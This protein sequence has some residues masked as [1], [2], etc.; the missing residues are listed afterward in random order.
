[1]KYKEKKKKDLKDERPRYNAEVL[2]GYIQRHHS[3]THS[4]DLKTKASPIGTQTLTLIALILRS[5][6]F[7]LVSYPNPNRYFLHFLL[8]VSRENQENG[9]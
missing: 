7:P 5:W 8:S 6:L 4:C 1:M 9:K 3:S 2:M